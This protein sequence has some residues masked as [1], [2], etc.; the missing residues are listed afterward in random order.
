[1]V[2]ARSRHIA[3]A[4]LRLFEVEFDLLL[5]SAERDVGSELVF[6]GEIA[7]YH[8]IMRK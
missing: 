5:V 7:Q 8:M 6:G 1:M 4:V 2:A 3:V